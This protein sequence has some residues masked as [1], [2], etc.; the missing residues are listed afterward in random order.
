MEGRTIAFKINAIL[1][2]ANILQAEL[3][4]KELE[5]EER[6]E[7]AASYLNKITKLQ[8]EL[9]DEKSK[10]DESYIELTYPFSFL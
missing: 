4:L 7:L 5:S 8:K 1:N 10:D 6:L 2:N 9:K 3:D